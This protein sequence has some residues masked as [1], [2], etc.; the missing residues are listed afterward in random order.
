IIG[1]PLEILPAVPIA[2]GQIQRPG[3]LAAQRELR[4]RTIAVAV[5]VVVADAAVAPQTHRAVEGETRAERPQVLH[6]QLVRLTAAADAARREE[7]PD[8][9]A[10]VA[11]PVLTHTRHL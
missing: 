10:H 8:A 4:A 11:D 1:I 3:Q 5:A 7:P 9:V 6:L 2:A